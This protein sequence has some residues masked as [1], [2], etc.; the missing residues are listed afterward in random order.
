MP[1]RLLKKRR[2]KEMQC[3][4]AEIFWGLAVTAV[5]ALLYSLGVF[6]S[7][8]LFFG[9]FATRLRGPLP[10]PPEIAIIAIDQE[11]AQSVGVWPLPR[12][13]YAR[14]VDILADAGAAAVGTNVFFS[15]ESVQERDLALAAAIR[16]AGTVYL[17]C[18]LESDPQSNRYV[19][20]IRNIPPLREAAKA[21]GIVNMPADPDGVTRRVVLGIPFEDALHWQLGLLIARDRFGAAARCGGDPSSRQIEIG[22]PGG[23]ALSIPTDDARTMVIDWNGPW[24]RSFHRYSLAD[25]LE[26]AAHAGKG[27]RPSVPLEELRGRICLVGPTM[28]GAYDAIRTPFD[29]TAPSIAVHATIVSQ[30]LARRFVTPLPRS[31]NLAAILITGFIVS[32]AASRL[33][34]ATAMAAT[35][36][37]CACYLAFCLVMY[38]RFRVHTAVFFPLAAALGAYLAMSIHREISISIERA[39]LLYLATTDGLTG[40]HLVGHV[41]L[42]LDAEISESRRLRSPLSLIMAD[43]DHFKQ[44]NDAGG[45]L[46]GDFVLRET[47]KV[48][49]SSCRT[50]DIA[51]RYGGE[52]FI[53]VLPDTTLAEARVAAERLRAEVAR[54]PFVH[55]ERRYAVTMSLGVA[56]LSEFDTADDLIK[57]ADEALY[58]AKRSGRNRVCVAAAAGAQTPIRL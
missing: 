13:V 30:I 27:D 51:G 31:R 43:L 55:E 3:S 22:L 38:L 36:A 50:L 19:R 28:P 20:L 11:S 12:D 29:G 9:D 35:L 40:L 37:G 49:S 45:H 39:R 5:A 1:R 26:S 54:H 6:K 47:A 4:R 24:A 21:E 57:R 7:F 41:R 33:R 42:L 16:R 46:D 2:R 8:D 44:V 56:E 14:L 52:E 15:E 17:P 32:L 25:V 34:P 58:A 53:L 10:P 23:S 18:V 48:L